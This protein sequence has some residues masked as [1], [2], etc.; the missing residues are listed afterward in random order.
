VIVVFAAALG[1]ALALMSGGGGQ[2]HARGN[3]LQHGHARSCTT[4]RAEARAVASKVL[5]APVSVT[6]PIS[7][8]VRSGAAAV[9]MSE[10]VVER[11]VAT[12]ELDVRQGAVSASRAC[13]RG[14][15]KDAARSA[16]LTRAY[17]KALVAAHARADRGA[18]KAIQALAAR[19]LPALI[20]SARRQ[21]DARARRATRA[22]R[23]ELVAR[24]RARIP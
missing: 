20:A 18:A 7:V 1:G 17:K 15:T 19:E 24:A 16:A 23:R 2:P 14:S 9:T 11:A 10:N 13:A 4:A 21:L 12:R 5:R 8:T 6:Q 22:A 3:A